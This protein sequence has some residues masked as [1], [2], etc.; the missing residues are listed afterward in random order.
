MCGR[1]GDPIVHRRRVESLPPGRPF[2][3]SHRCFGVPAVPRH[4]LTWSRSVCEVVTKFK[5]LPRHGC[6]QCPLSCVTVDE[7][8]PFTSTHLWSVEGV[9]WTRG[10][11]SHPQGS[12]LVMFRGAAA[13]HE[14]RQKN[15]WK[16]GVPLH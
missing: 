11:S 3:P 1:T 14:G 9:D 2:P 16:K 13:T 4:R 15:E 8:T 6:T 10:H 12:P 5:F 7:E